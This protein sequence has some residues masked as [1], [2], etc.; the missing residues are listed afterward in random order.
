MSIKIFV[1]F[2]FTALTLLVVLQ[3]SKAQNETTTLQPNAILT[4]V[5][6]AEIAGTEVLLKDLK[7]TLS[8]VSLRL[9]KEK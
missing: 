2:L 1:T 7:L 5:D 6:P 4:I 8:E 9:H 3:I